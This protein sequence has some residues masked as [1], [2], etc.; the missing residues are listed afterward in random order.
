MNNNFECCI[1]IDL[2]TITTKIWITHG[3]Y[4]P[5]HI[6][7]CIERI[8]QKNF[9]FEII[10]LHVINND[11]VFDDLK[12]L[13]SFAMS[14]L[15]DHNSIKYKNGTTVMLDKILELFPSNIKYFS[16]WFRNDISMVNASTMK[17]I[18][19]LQNLEKIKT[20][21]LHACH[22]DLNVED[23]SA[24]I[25]KFKNTQIFFGFASNISPEYEEKLDSLI[26]EIIES[27]VP[28]RVIAYDGQDRGKLKIMISRYAPYNIVPVTITGAPPAGVD[29][30]EDLENN[31][32]FDVE[33][34][35]VVDD[36]RE[37][38]ETESDAGSTCCV[39]FLFNRIKNFFKS[40]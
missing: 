39:A 22:D 26:D 21:K 37:S 29:E 33:N 9:R 16:F 24:F 3:L 34:E 35:S 19:K 32:G 18:L 8:V 5:F 14:V 30:V 31:N 2:N 23:L 25:K 40:K 1:K 4:I 20:F 15:L 10:S 6:Q 38:D 13:A 17:N 27:N 7:N 11:I 36:K 12:L 28:N